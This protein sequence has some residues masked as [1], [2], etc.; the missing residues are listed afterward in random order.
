MKKLAFALIFTIGMSAFGI[1]GQTKNDDILK[2]LRVSGSDKLAN[3]VMNAM[4]PQFRQLVPDIPDEFWI[5]FNEKL[6]VDDL[7]YACI[8]AYDKFYTHDEIK[9]LIAFYESSLGKKMVEVT[10]LLVQ[11]TMAIG[12]KW[13][14]KLSQDIVDELIREGYV[15]N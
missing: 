14:E 5:K 1:Y 6:N 2:L 9:Q 8:P 7:L 4:I 11:E 13:G 12:Q 15:K 10:P 3:Q